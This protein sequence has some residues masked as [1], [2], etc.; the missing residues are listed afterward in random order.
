M[1][2][3]Q[4]FDAKTLRMLVVH[5][6]HVWSLEQCRE[7]EETLVFQE[8]LQKHEVTHHK[9]EYRANKVSRKHKNSEHLQISAPLL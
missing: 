9:V 1:V 6:E 8:R 3:R 2:T 7:D 5:E 4:S